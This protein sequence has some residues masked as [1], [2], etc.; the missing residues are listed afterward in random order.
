MLEYIVF[1]SELVKLQ[2]SMKECLFMCVRFGVSFQGAWP[3]SEEIV[4]SL[5]LE[6]LAV[7]GVHN[8][9][10]CQKGGRFRNDNV[11]VKLAHCWFY[12]CFCFNLCLL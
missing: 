7:Y 10:S 4:I 5:R 1:F 2:I 9:P 12:G 6:P 8:I 3:G 11:C